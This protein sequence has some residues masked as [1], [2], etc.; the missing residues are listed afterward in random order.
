MIKAIQAYL[1]IGSED[2]AIRRRIAVYTILFDVVLMIW[3]GE[4]MRMQM[5]PT[6]FAMAAGQMTWVLTSYV[7][8]AMWDAHLTRQSD[9]D[10]IIKSGDLNKSRP[11]IPP[12]A[13]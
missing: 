10:F 11:N 3:S 12:A 5:A 4:W 9:N 8:A 6:V 13:N 2:W 1:N 7:F